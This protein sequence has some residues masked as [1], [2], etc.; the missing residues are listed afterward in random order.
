MLKSI[1][2]CPY[3]HFEA[4]LH[5]CNLTEPDHSMYHDSAKSIICNVII[6]NQ[7]EVYAP[8]QCPEMTH[9][10]RNHQYFL[11]KDKFREYK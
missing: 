7:N 6:A 8:V 1:C 9:D 2:I 10:F 4:H 11:Q 3:L 5:I